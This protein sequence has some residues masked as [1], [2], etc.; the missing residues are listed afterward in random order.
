MQ[1]GM[2]VYA[3]APAAARAYVEAGRARADDYYLTEGTG[4]ARRFTATDGRVADLGPL[5]GDAYESWVAGRDP[6]SGE[7]RGR[8]REDARAVRFVEVVVN[9]PKSWS[10]AAAL[11]PDVAAAYEGAQDRAAAQIIGW[12]SQ[13]ATTRVGPRGGQIPVPLGGL[14]AVTVRHYTSRAG[15]PHWHLHLQLNS[16]VYAAGKWRGLFTVDIRDSL[17]AINGIGHAAMA[18]DP[19][20]N[21]ALG[22]H[23][24]SKDPAGEIVQLAQFVSPFSARHHQIALNVDRYERE[25]T[26]A[27]PGEQPGPALRRSW[28]ARAWAEDRPDKAAALPGADMR[29]RWRTALADCGYRHPGRPVTLTPTAVGALDR[30]HLAARAPSRLAAGRS[31]WNPADVRGVVERL[32]AEAGVVTEPAVRI[33]LAEDLTA[34]AL[35]R[36]LPLLDRIGVP[37]HI[38]GWTSPAVLEVEADLTGRLAARAATDTH[39]VPAGVPALRVEQMTAPAAEYLTPA[40]AGVRPPAGQVSP[41][42]A[43]VTPLPQARA[44]VGRLDAGQAAAAVV[45]AGDRQLVVIEGAAGAGKTTTLAATRDL[46]AEQGRRLMVVTPT[47]KAARVAAA[48]MNTAAG[49]AAWLAYQHGW[50]WDDDGAWTRLSVG[51]ADPVTGRVFSGPTEAARL[52]AGDLLVVDEAGM[53]DQD[54][55]RA[56]L[57]VADE[58]SARVAL[59]G[60]QHQ[61]AAVGRGG[62]LDLAAGHVD[63]SAHLTLAG[64]HRFVRLDG[65]GRAVADREYAELSLAMRAGTDPAAVFDA[66]LARGQIEVHPDEA[67]LQDAVAGAAVQA[68]AAGER[69]AVVVDTRQQAGDLNAVIHDRLLGA[70]HVADTPAAVI[71]TGQRVGAGDL[72]A[73]R[74]NDRTLMVAN[75]ESWTITAVHPDGSL[76]ITPEVTPTAPGGA[77]AAAVRVLPA[78]YV[79]EHVELAYAS[80]VHGVQGETVPTAHLVIGEGTGAASAYV[81]MTRGRLANIAHLIAA[82]VDAAR[83]AWVAVFGRDRADRGPGEAGLAAARAAAEYSPAPVPAGVE[84]L[85][86]VVGQLCAAWTEQELAS[87]RLRNV[88]HRLSRAEAQAG[89]WEHCREVLTPLEQRFETA[90]TASESADR[91][92]AGSAD[93]LAGAADRIA[94]GLRRAWD[95]QLWDAEADARIVAAGPGRLGLHRAGFRDATQ[96]L[97]D[98]AGTWAPAFPGAYPNTDAMR[99]HPAGYTSGVPAVGQA[100]LERARDLAA[101][102]NPEQAMRVRQTAQSRAGYDQAADAYFGAQ[103]DLREQSSLPTYDVGAAK[104]LPAL[105][106]EAR[107]AQERADRADQRVQRL[108]DDPVIDSQPDPAGVLTAA[109]GRWE[110]ERAA[111]RIAARHGHGTAAPSAPPRPFPDQDLPHYTPNVGRG[112]GISC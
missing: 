79:R 72:I 61:L 97:E 94:A 42:A 16:R 34:R 96:R 37:E 81:G 1:G 106:A 49:S 101:A 41:L 90:R 31:A 3:G 20:F 54:T 69:A 32:I 107:T 48:E 7:P 88:E 67:E 110:H 56:L 52:R 111:E 60:D 89:W 14:E 86:T 40:G 44:A 105:R 71:G 112:P 23:G 74:R 4:I 38:R 12:V 18:T 76:T 47:L 43:E 2:K 91:A 28:D 53:L 35:H 9:G 26:T 93:V 33:E 98:W 13:H 36:C 45:L 73:T 87:D 29:G 55:A 11:H 58:A 57:T 77:P 68:F 66:L 104:A 25:W 80:T 64:I 51:Q 46:L 8:L 62:V 82:D 5:T 39:D 78:G 15:D 21:A 83:E 59:L 75:R 92:S 100:L 102:E 17:G 108:R 27:P 24:Y 84:Q 109:R 6:V 99:A 70:G 85:E 65:S 50:R 30:D 19:E 95:S 63:P 22:A 10:L 103:R